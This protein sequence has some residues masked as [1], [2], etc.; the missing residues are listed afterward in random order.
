[1]SFNTLIFVKLFNRTSHFYNTQKFYLIHFIYHRLVAIFNNDTKWVHVRTHHWKNLT[2]N[3]ETYSQRNSDV[4]LEYPYKLFL[5]CR[6]QT[7]L[8]SAWQYYNALKQ[9]L[10]CNKSHLAYSPL[11]NDPKMLRKISKQMLLRIMKHIN[12][13]HMY[14]CI[15]TPHDHDCDKSSNILVSYQ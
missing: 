10:R 2:I 11:Y 13:W 14:S 6:I 1:M 9:R 7:V 3:I 4:P 15:F 12:F 8:P 5:L